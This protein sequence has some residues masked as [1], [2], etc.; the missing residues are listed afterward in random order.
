MT[1]P[2]SDPSAALDY[3]LAYARRGWRV[4]P[5][6]PKAKHPSITAWQTEGS[7][8]V[9]RIKHWWGA[10]SDFGI[11]IVTGA[12]SG[13]VVLDVDEHG[14]VRGSDTLADLEAT[15][16]RL[17]DTLEVL[18]GGGGRHLY[19]AHPGHEVRNDAGR[20]LGPGLDV[21]GDGGQ[22]IAPP[23]MHASGQR[24][25]FELSS[26]WPDRVLVAPLPGWLD[27]LLSSSQA[28]APTR[29]VASN[30]ATGPVIAGPRTRA[31]TSC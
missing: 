6:P 12:E 17:P 14:H 29:E 9:E 24:Y 5:V 25:E 30:A 4:V 23:S 28:P 31:G 13:L 11:G 7:T 27:E 26:G 16:E 10:S 22:V 20:R 8:D 18:T 19:F 3:A 1:D 21:R 15:Y 2:V